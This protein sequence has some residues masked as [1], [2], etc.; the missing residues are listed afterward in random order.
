MTEKEWMIDSVNFGN[1]KLTTKSTLNKNFLPIEKSEEEEID[2]DVFFE[3]KSIFQKIA[4]WK[5][6]S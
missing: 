3:Q 2:S 1:L 4:L 6:N 5:L